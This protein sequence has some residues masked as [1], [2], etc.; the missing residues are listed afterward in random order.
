MTALEISSQNSAQL[1][2]PGIEPTAIT[3]NHGPNFLLAHPRGSG[4]FLVL[5]NRIFSSEES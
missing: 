2:C 1:A 4:E 3:F 5:R